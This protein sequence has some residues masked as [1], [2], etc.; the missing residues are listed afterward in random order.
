MTFRM[1]IVESA[2]SSRLDD[3]DAELSAAVALIQLWFYRLQQEFFDCL[4][5][6]VDSSSDDVDS[7]VDAAKSVVLNGE[8]SRDPLVLVR[9]RNVLTCLH[10]YIQLIGI[11]CR[12]VDNRSYP[13]YKSY[14]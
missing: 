5:L 11:F 1:Q 7:L 14:I 3:Y 6:L 13:S 12:T 2:R 9:C 8:L 10:T 4:C